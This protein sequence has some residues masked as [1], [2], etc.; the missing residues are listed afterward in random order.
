MQ[1]ELAQRGQRPPRPVQVPALVGVDHQQ[2]IG[3][4]HRAHRGHPGHVLGQVGTAHLDLDAPVAGR[5]PAPGLLDQLLQRVVQVDAAAVHG[6]LVAPA[7][8]H[9]GQRLGAAAQVP[10]RQVD[11]GQRDRGDPA[12]SRLAQVSPQ[13]VPHHL[14]MGGQPDQRLPDVV[15]EQRPHRVRADLRRPREA[16]AGTPVGERDMGDDHVVGR[17]VR[18]PRARQ[19]GGAQLGTQ[20]RDRHDATRS[21][22]VLISVSSSSRCSPLTSTRGGRTEPTSRPRSRTPALT[23]ETG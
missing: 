11:A 7:A 12:G 21:S 4:D 14:G 9:V 18:A 5:D 16:G 15:V 1:P 22:P 10:Q 13:A 19:R 3:A 2:P 6:K 20:V 23:S 17:H 8:Q